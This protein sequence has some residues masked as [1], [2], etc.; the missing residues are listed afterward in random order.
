[1]ENSVK[2]NLNVD[3]KGTGTQLIQYF[4]EQSNLSYYLLLSEQSAQAVIEFRN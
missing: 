4:A 1:V 3:Q 2:P